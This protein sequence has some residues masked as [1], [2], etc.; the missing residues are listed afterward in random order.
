MEH[1]RQEKD[2]GTLEPRKGLWNIRAKERTME[3]QSQER[4]REFIAV[5]VLIKYIRFSKNFY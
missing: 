2:Y 1:L 3:H 4:T 5:D